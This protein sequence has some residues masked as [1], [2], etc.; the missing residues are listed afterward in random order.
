MS[1]KYLRNIF[2]FEEAVHVQNAISVSVIDVS[3][4]TEPY[5]WFMRYFSVMAYF[6]W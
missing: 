5:S 6:G 2:Q 1:Y 4:R 3:M